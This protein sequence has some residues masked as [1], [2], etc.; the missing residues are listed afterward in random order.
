MSSVTEPWHVQQLV[1][2]L[3]I[4]ADVD[5]SHAVRLRTHQPQPK[6]QPLPSMPTRL[7]SSEPIQPYRMRVIFPWN[8]RP[9]AHP[10]ATAGT[11]HLEPQMSNAS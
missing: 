9:R 8:S 7:R 6:D 5:G 10:R 3:D 11:N 2:N 4:T 1:Q